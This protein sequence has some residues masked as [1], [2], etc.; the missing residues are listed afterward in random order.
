MM[1]TAIR[2][3]FQIQFNCS[4]AGGCTRLSSSYSVIIHICNEALCLRN[5]I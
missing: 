3:W 1:P 5:A 2:I 4:R